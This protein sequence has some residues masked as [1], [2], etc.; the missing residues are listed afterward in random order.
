MEI[1]P[2]EWEE[3]IQVPEVIEGWGLEDLIEEGDFGAQQLADMVYGVKFDYITGGPGYCGE[4]FI[5]MGDGLSTYP[6]VI[7]RESGKLNPAQLE[8]P[9]FGESHKRYRVTLTV[10]IGAD[11]PEEAVHEFKRSSVQHWATSD[12]VEVKE[13]V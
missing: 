11:T 2:H 12:N 6:M 4:L 13:D 7:T 1:A 8:P 10:S 3:L 5:L 9:Y